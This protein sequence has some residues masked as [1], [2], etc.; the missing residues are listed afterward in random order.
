MLGYPNPNRTAL[1]GSPELTDGH[2]R[3][4]SSHAGVV[5]EALFRGDGGQPDVAAKPNLPA[6]PTYSSWLNWLE[7]EFAALRYFALNGTDHQNH[8][9]QDDAIGAYIRW[10]NQH[11]EPKRDGA[12]GRDRGRCREAEAAAHHPGSGRPARGV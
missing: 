9:E 8:G 6:L 11:A 10:R 4:A 5:G 3:C 1:A 7:C 2:A 12:V